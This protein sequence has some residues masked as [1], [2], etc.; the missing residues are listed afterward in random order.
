MNP[1]ACIAVRLEALGTARGGVAE[2][3]WGRAAADEIEA[4]HGQGAEVLAPKCA[5]LVGNR[6]LKVVLFKRRN[7]CKSVSMIQCVHST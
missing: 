1:E 2:H 4:I 7:L 3:S 6:A 5:E